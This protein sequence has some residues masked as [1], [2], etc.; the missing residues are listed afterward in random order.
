MNI[1]NDSYAMLLLCSDLALR[2]FDNGAKPY[3]VSQWSH[4]AERLF[5][6]NFTPST[7][8]DVSS[9]DIRQ[10]LSL[11]HQEA[12]RIEM[13]LSRAGQ[14]GIEL[15]AL[16]EKGIFTLTRS[17][18]DYPIALKNKLKKLAPPI[19]YYAGNLSLLSNNGVAV[20]G[21]RDL[22]EA[23][24][25]F[26]EKL[27]RRC[28]N[29]GLNI[30]SGGARGVDSIAENVAN[31]SDGTTVI[32]VA[33][34]LE[35]KIR[36][37]ETREAIM[38]RQSIILSSFRPDM[39]FQTYA[40]MER[41]KYVYALSDYVVVISSDYNKGGTWAGATENIKRGWVPMFVRNEDNIPK[42]N[43]NLLKNKDV[44]PISQEILNN[45]SINIFDWFKSQTIKSEDNIEP[46]QLSLFD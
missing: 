38:R 18:A 40:A 10:K 30:V 24:L 22:D 41:N 43:I 5:Q 28:T 20:V 8:F 45:E 19:L 3:T 4:L 1:L 31:N 42:G 27:S 36:K 23:G 9:E 2:N 14:F 15:S 12:A 33:D 44:Y 46:Q 35:K 39:P 16:N 13:L 29:D 34:S 32:F 11:S 6:N 25:R 26:T 7:L 21:S 17:D 37:K